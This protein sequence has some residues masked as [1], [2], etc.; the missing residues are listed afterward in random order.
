MR[1]E[2]EIKINIRKVSQVFCCCCCFLLFISK[3]SSLHRGRSSFLS[4]QI[5]RITSLSFP[6]SWRD[7]RINILIESRVVIKEKDERRGE[8]TLDIF[9]WHQ[10]VEWSSNTGNLMSCVSLLIAVKL[11]R[12]ENEVGVGTHAAKLEAAAVN[13]VT[14]ASRLS[15]SIACTSKTFRH[16]ISQQTGNNIRT[17]E[18]V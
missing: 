9:A 6:S 16:C 11:T 8:K 10:S 12:M 13:V 18:Y 17:S 15:S 2:M 5:T 4:W 14:F 1:V 7:A 3:S